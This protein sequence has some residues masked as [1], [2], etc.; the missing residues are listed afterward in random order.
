MTSR[1]VF[2]LRVLGISAST[3]YGWRK[4]RQAPSRRAI[5]D[6]ELL[7]LIDEIRGECEFAAHPRKHGV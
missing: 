1:L 5:E 6:A 7:G 3:Y 2:V 4:A